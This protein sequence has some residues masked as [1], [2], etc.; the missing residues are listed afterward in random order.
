MFKKLRSLDGSDVV[1]PRARQ[2]EP[3]SRN[4]GE[5]FSVG[6]YLDLMTGA[7]KERSDNAADGSRPDH[8]HPH[9][10]ILLG[11]LLSSGCTTRR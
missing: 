1:A 3:V 9:A 10:Q 7:G 8:R 6:G 4:L 2:G 5:V 11:C